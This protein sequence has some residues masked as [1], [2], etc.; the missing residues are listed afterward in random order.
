MEV[1]PRGCISPRKWV[2]FLKIFT[3]PQQLKSETTDCIKKLREKQKRCRPPISTGWAWCRWR[4]R[5]IIGKKGWKR[6]MFSLSTIL[7]N[8]NACDNN[9][10]IKLSVLCARLSWVYRQLLST[11]KHILSHPIVSY[12]RVK[13]RSLAAISMSDQT[14]SNAISVEWSFL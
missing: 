2:H 9:I 7:M 3:G 4:L 6:F 11:N 13:L 1:L 5:T 8:R 12:H 10:A 14:H